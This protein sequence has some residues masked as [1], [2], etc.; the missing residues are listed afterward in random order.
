[1][2]LATTQPVPPPRVLVPWWRRP[3]V[4]APEPTAPPLH[5]LIADLQRLENEAERLLGDDS[6]VARGQRL[7]AV[8]LAFDLVLLDAARALEV[9]VPHERAPFT[10][11]E[12]FRVTV[13][14]TAAGLRW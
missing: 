14:L 9:A 2:G 8:R 5:R 11:D 7:L 10:S 1:V 13:D 4:R 12:R 6:V 3:F